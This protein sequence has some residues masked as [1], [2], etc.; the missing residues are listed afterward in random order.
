[1][2]SPT[3]IDLRSS[4]ENTKHRGLIDPNCIFDPDIILLP[5]EQEGFHLLFPNWHET[6]FFK[7]PTI[8][9]MTRML[10]DVDLDRITKRSVI[11]ADYT[12]T[13][14]PYAPST[15]NDTTHFRAYSC[16]P[17]EAQSCPMPL[18]STDTTMNARTFESRQGQLTVKDIIGAV[19]YLKGLIATSQD[20]PLHNPCK[21]GLMATRLGDVHFNF[22]TNERKVLKDSLCKAASGGALEIKEA[23]DAILAAVGF[24]DD[25]N[26]NYNLDNLLDCFSSWNHLKRNELV[27]ENYKTDAVERVEDW[28]KGDMQRLLLCRDI[29][30]QL[31]GHT[32]IETMSKQVSL[33]TTIMDVV[34][35][36]LFGQPKE[37]KVPLPKHAVTLEELIGKGY[38]VDVYNSVG[39]SVRGRRIRIGQLNLTQMRAIACFC[40]FNLSEPSP[41]KE[42][43]GIY[44]N[45]CST[46]SSFKLAIDMG[47]LDYDNFTEVKTVLFCGCNLIYFTHMTSPHGYEYIMLCNEFLSWRQRIKRDFSNSLTRDA[48][49]LLVTMTA[50]IVSFTGIIQV[51]QG[52]VKN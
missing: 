7:R 49:A 14:L 27:P 16:V 8:R 15:K 29:S 2:Q 18:D 35:L 11:I 25:D 9:D 43:L 19:H 44:F 24:S 34:V 12:L 46:P 5:S 38:I 41:A 10:K 48:F 23:A 17:F 1:M 42:L 50:L 39:F 40:D 28:L 21:V 52:F 20:W 31:F 4:A 33:N 22:R 32:Q 37:H 47:I 3:S 51:V 13:P 36:E 6:S 45:L 30:L 26:Y